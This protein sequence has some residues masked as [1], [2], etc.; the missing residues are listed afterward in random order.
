MQDIYQKLLREA[1][2][3][4]DA[5][6]ACRILLELG[7]VFAGRNESAGALGCFQRALAIAVDLGDPALEER[8]LEPL[9]LVLL[10]LQGV[11]EAAACFQRLLEIV[12]AAGDRAKEARVLGLLGG[13]DRR[14]GRMGEAAVRLKRAQD[15]LREVKDPYAYYA[16][17]KIRA[18][19]VRRRGNI[20]LAIQLLEEALRMAR[21]AGQDHEVEELLSDLAE[22][23]LECGHDDRARA[24][25]EEALRL[26]RD[27]DDIPVETI[28]LLRLSE[29]DR[30]AGDTL[31][32]LFRVR[33]ALDRVSDLTEPD[34]ACRASV[35]L[36]R[37]LERQGRE[38]A[39]RAALAEAVQHARAGGLEGAEAEALLSYACLLVRAR[40]PEIRDPEVAVAAAERALDLGGETTPTPWII[41]SRAYRL[42][43][44]R[45]RSK[46]MRERAQLIGKK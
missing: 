29:L 25:L 46:E 3:Q 15:L 18:D 10:H 9:G 36:G 32:A 12:R 33:T 2:E 13:L 6:G 20:A 45:Q 24:C 40:D 5:L 38:R 23:H 28:H 8:A 11:E 44:D 42:L 34:I 19:T 26:T 27:L 14:R 30:K 16:I 21:Q 31:S 17:L 41:L 35:L 22:L 43:G 1:E 37:I 7:H 4:D 39:A